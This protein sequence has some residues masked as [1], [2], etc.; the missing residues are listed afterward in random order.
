MQTG[1][2]IVTKI[3]TWIW[4]PSNSNE[5]LMDWFA[6]FVLV[7]IASYLWSTVIKVVD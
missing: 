3:Y 5:T 2:G 4:H 7:L 1:E 6:F